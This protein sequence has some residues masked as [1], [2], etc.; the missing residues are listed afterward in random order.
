MHILFTN[1]WMTVFLA[2]SSQFQAYLEL[3]FSCTR[4]GPAGELSGDGFEMLIYQE[5][6]WWMK[7]VL[8]RL[9]AQLQWQC[10]AN[11]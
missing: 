8:E 1:Q 6:W 4:F 7:W 5:H 11:W 3:A 9:S 10:F 2:T